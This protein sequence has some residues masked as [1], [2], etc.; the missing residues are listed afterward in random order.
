MTNRL[1]YMCQWVLKIA[2][3]NLMVIVGT[4]TG[5][6]IFGFFPAIFSGI[7]IFSFLFEQGIDISIRD[8]FIVYYKKVFITAN[9]YGYIG[10]GIVVL[11]FSHI[12]FFQHIPSSG[13]SFFLKISTFFLFSLLISVMAF[14]LPT[15]IDYKM[16]LTRASKFVLFCM[17]KAHLIFFTIIGI[18]L[19]MLFFI[20][21]LGADIFLFFGIYCCFI[22]LINR[23][24]NRKVVLSN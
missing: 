22:A 3:V 13:V 20:F 1:M 18:V 10:L 19:Q 14:A 16:D 4:L 7:M 5:G 21:F 11:G 15:I 17:S 2:Q 12:M 9:K 8:R 24:L 6:I 23:G